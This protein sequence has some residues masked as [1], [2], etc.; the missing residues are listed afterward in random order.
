[1]WKILCVTLSPE[2]G[3][4]YYLFEFP[5]HVDRQAGVYLVPFLP[6]FQ[7]RAWSRALIP[8]K[9]GAVLLGL[10]P[11]SFL[12]WKNAR[13]RRSPTPKAVV[14]IFASDLVKFVDKAWNSFNLSPFC[15]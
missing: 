7:P 9:T 10:V 3:W 1:M 12:P 4:L 13:P 6:G 8:N 15:C 11:P 2:I 14:D 5:G